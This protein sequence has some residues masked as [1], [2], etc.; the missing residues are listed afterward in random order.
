M[1]S[2]SDFKILAIDDEK[3]ILLLLKYN[4]EQEG[5]TVKTSD[6]GIEALK[7]AEKFSPHLILLDIMMPKLDGIETCIKLRSIENLFNSYII[8]LTAREEEYSE[9]AAFDAGADDYITKPIK[10]RALISRINSFFKRRFSS[11]DTSLV[12]EIESLKID[13]NSYTTILDGKKIYLPKKEF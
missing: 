5:Y 12:Q 10:P 13:K 2:K 11:K 4:L 9:V 7:I 8:F 6:S 1:S 3:D